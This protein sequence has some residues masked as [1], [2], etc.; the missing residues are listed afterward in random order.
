M[1]DTGNHR[2]VSYDPLLQDPKSFGKRGTAAGEFTSPVGIAVAPSGLVYVADAGNRRIQVLAA[3]GDLVGEP[4]LRGLGGQRRAGPGRRQGRDDLRHRPRGGRRRRPRPV[5]RR[6]SAGSSPTTRAASS[7]TRPVS[8]STGKTVSSTSSTPETHPWPKSLC[9]TGGLLERCRA[10]PGPGALAADGR[11][12]PLHRDPRDRGRPDAL[13]GAR[14]AAAPPRRVDPR[15]P[16][17]D[18]LARRATG[19][20][21]R[22]T[23]ARSSITS[24]RSSTRSSA[25]PTSRRG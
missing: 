9:R 17:L 22:P 18:A 21:T 25:R 12:P 1:T 23:T 6:A 24:T 2:V 11:S 20:T 5:G 19:G 16:V 7:R 4:P 13:L 10:R 14:R 8:R 3:S 15:V